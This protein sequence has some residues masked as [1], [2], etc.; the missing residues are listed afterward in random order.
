M[1]NNVVHLAST[2]IENQEGEPLKRQCAKERVYK[3]ITCPKMVHE[4]NQF[5]GGVDLCDMFLPLFRIRLQSN[6]WNMFVFYYLI[7]VAVT[8]KWLLYRR[9][10]LLMKDTIPLLLQFQA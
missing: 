3:F 1:D 6:K 5:M 10:H 7:K 2:F 9:Q 8:N 4:Y